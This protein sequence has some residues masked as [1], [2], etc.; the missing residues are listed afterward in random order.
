M[1]Y[2]GD[3]NNAIAAVTVQGGAWV[4]EEIP[5]ALIFE[6]NRLMSNVN[7]IA[8]GEGYGVSSGVRFYRTTLEKIDHDSDH[9]HFAPVRLGFWYWNTLKNRMIDT[10]LVGITEDEMTP[11]FYGGTGKMEVFYGERKT[12]QFFDG[13]SRPLAGKTVTLA[14]GGITQRQQTDAQGRAAFD[15]LS[16]RHFKFGNSQENDGIT[17]TPERIDYQAQEHVFSAPGY[18]S[19][20]VMP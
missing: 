15:I 13:S 10:K 11:D 9:G 6:D 1:Y 5:D 17:G 16:V 20:R 3:V 12:L 4:S 19:Y 7:H 18:H 8:I 2:N 14:I